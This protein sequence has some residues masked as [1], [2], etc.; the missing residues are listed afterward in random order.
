MHCRKRRRFTLRALILRFARFFRF[1][2][3]SGDGTYKAG[4]QVSINAAIPSGYTFIRW[5]G[6]ESG[7]RIEQL[8]TPNTTYTM[9][10]SHT[11]LVAAFAKIEAWFPPGP[12]GSYKG[13][14]LPKNPQQAEKP[15]F[16]HKT[17]VTVNVGEA[18][19]AYYNVVWSDI[20]V[21]LGWFPIREQEG[22][23]H[24]AELLTY[25][26]KERGGASLAK[27]ANLKSD[28]FQDEGDGVYVASVWYEGK[29]TQAQAVTKSGAN[30]E[31]V[32]PHALAGFKLQVRNGNSSFVVLT[33]SGTLLPIDIKKVWSDQLSG[34]EVNFFQRSGTPTMERAEQISPTF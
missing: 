7:G 29:W 4:E 17:R 19:G 20:K 28:L 14:F 34:V 12:E 1:K 21:K 33:T 27:D 16:E 11:T 24:S 32:M 31:P 5:Y 13:L 30:Q 22:I 18:G 26:D 8:Y 25:W 6:G 3:G 23:W 9:G 15:R 10:H 2:N